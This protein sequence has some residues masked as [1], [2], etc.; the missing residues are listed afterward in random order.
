M[1][2]SSAGRGRQTPLLAEAVDELGHL[3]QALEIEQMRS[4]REGSR[5][6]DGAVR[7]A[8]GDGSMA[9]IGQA[10]DDV[11]VLAVTDA[12][13]GELLSAEGMMGMRDGHES[14]SKL[15]G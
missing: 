1:A 15:G 4:S 14:R 5:G 13:D 6:G 7:G 11:R 3:P 8:E 10:E 9:A 2:G 12:D